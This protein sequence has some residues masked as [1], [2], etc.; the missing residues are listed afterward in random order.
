MQLRRVRDGVLRRLDRGVGGGQLDLRG[1]ERGVELIEPGAGGGLV[2]VR[3][4]HVRR[5]AEIAQ[6]FLGGRAVG[7]TLVAHPRQLRHGPRRGVFL[8]PRD[9]EVLRRQR[10][11]PP[12]RRLRAGRI[13]PQ[14]ND[15]FARGDLRLQRIAQR[16]LRRQRPAR[17]DARR[18]I[19]RRDGGGQHRLGEDQ[20]A[21]G[22]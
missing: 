8:I 9:L 1:G 10:V 5:R 4:R 12:R 20:L 16:L 17:V 11:Q 13:Q 18:R 15:L 19:Q 2:R 3:P 6:R 7:G 22:G 14:V 21:L